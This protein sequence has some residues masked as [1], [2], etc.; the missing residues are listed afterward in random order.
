[1]QKKKWENY[2]VDWS[3]QLGK[4]IGPDGSLTESGMEE[5]FGRNMK[6]LSGEM[7]KLAEDKLKVLRKRWEKRYKPNK[8][9]DI[10]S[11]GRIM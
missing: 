1:M 11:L 5:L 10:R 2:A 4:S 8:T 6:V 9:W 7:M 3:S